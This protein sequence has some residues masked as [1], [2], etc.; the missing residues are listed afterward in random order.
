MIFLLKRIGAMVLVAILIGL[1]I[2][3]LLLAVSG[4]RYFMASMVAM[5]TFPLLIYA[6]LFIYRLVK[7]D[8]ETG[9]KKDE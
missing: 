6:Y 5:F 9:N 7:D 1:V 4:S 8:D 3:T 2:L